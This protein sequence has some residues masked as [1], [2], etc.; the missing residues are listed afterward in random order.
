M[1]VSSIRS[2]GPTA[3][4]PGSDHTR[5]ANA[6]GKAEARALPPA[7]QPGVQGPE[8]PAIVEDSETYAG[9]SPQRRALGNIV[10]ASLGNNSIVNGDVGRVARS[11]ALHGDV[12]AVYRQQIRMG[13]SF[14]DKVEFV[15]REP[16]GSIRLAS[17]L[18]SYAIDATYSFSV[19]RNGEIPGSL[20]RMMQAEA[21]A[22]PTIRG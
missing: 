21:T 6:G 13:F 10:G 16:D 18:G 22:S 2:A 8:P 7:D 1:Q 17:L 4:A 14:G 3:F 5:P 20:G 12:I 11:I 19:A 15:S 9:S